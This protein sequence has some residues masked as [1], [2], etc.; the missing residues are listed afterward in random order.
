MRNTNKAFLQKNKNILNLLDQFKSLE[1]FMDDLGFLVFGRDM[2][3]CEKYMFSM[4]T[5]LNSSQATLGNIIDCCESFCLADT[6]TLL[7]KYRD[8]LFFCL[9]IVLYDANTRS[10]ITKNTSKMETNIK[11]WCE[12]GLSNLNISEV[13]STIGTSEHLKNVIIKYNLQKRFDI[14]GKRLNDYIHGNGHSYYNTSAV[15]F[16][17]KYLEQQVGDIVFITRYITTTF[18][19]LLVLI[20]PYY[21]MSTDYVDYLEIGQTPP[22]GPQHCVAPFV[23]EFFKDNIKIIDK[24]CYEY[25]KE[26]ICMDL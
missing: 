24:N 10:G 2:I 11:H 9:Y 23:A 14:I 16:D 21:I 4:Q 19:F 13:L 15:L 5:I 7:R 12:N 26:N 1:S 3:I 6:Y 25:L 20:S 8:D 17:D 18:L 22:D